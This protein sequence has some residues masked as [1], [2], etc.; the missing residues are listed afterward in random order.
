MPLSSNLLSYWDLN[1]GPPALLMWLIDSLLLRL[2][3]LPMRSH[4]FLTFK[5]LTPQILSSLSCTVSNSVLS[6]SHLV[7]MPICCNYFLFNKIKEKPAWTL[8]MPLGI[9][10]L[11]FQFIFIVKHFVSS[12]QFQSGLEAL[13]NSHLYLDAMSGSLR[14]SSYLT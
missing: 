4:L 9:T 3:N 13:L 8:T 11:F 5:V 7:N 12:T 2:P 10:V 14:C 6:C 1:T